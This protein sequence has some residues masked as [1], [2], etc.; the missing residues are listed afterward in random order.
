MPLRT[1]LHGQ[2]VCRLPSSSQLAATFFDG[3]TRAGPPGIFRVQ[4]T[5]ALFIAARPQVAEERESVSYRAS[6]Y[7]HL[8]VRPPGG[9]HLAE[10]DASRRGGRC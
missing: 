5:N 4:N 2:V 10:P 3:C 8:S 6:S 1:R 9:C 7:I